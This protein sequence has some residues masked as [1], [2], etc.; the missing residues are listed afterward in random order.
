MSKCEFVRPL[1]GLTYLLKKCTALQTPFL[2]IAYPT[3][4]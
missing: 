4:L 1:I 2:D 3:E